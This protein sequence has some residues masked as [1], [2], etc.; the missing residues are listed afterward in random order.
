MNALPVKGATETLYGE[1]QAGGP[2]GCTA[3]GR[4]ERQ[5]KERGRSWPVLLSIVIVEYNAV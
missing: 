4:A 5:A 1:D 3:G 2:A